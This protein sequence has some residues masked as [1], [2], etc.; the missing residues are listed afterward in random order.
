MKGRIS[1]GIFYAFFFSLYPLVAL[2]ST[3]SAVV[4]LADVLRSIWITVVGVL[5]LLGLFWIFT[6]KWHVGAILASVILILFF[7]YGHVYNIIKGT[8]VAGFDLGRHR[9]LLI[10]WAGFVLVAAFVSIRRKNSLYRLAPAL[11]AVS[12]M[13]LM[14][15]LVTIIKTGIEAKRD[16][17]RNPASYVESGVVL[18]GNED[19]LPD[20][21]YIITDAYARSDILLERYHYDNSYFMKFLAE[22]GFVIADQSTSNYLWT[23][24]SLGSSLNMDY[25]QNIVAGW[26][27]GDKVPSF[28]LIQ[29]NEVRRIFEANG[30]KTIGFATGWDATEFFDADVVLTPEMTNYQYLEK[31][32]V[33]ND[34]EGLLLS[35]SAV[36]VLIDIDSS[37][38]I[39]VEE[40][41]QQ[42]L[43]TRF[44]IQRSIIL[45]LFENLQKVPS[46]EGPKFVFAHIISPHPPII[47]GRNG[48]AVENIGPFNLDTPVDEPGEGNAAQYT[49][50]LEYIT[51]RLMETVDV[52]LRDS[53]REVYII[54][55]SD[56]GPGGG[57]E[58][59]N[60][61]E[62][63]ADR[64]S[65]L[66][67][68]YLPADCQERIYSTISPVNSF[69]VLFSCLS[70]ITYP[71][72]SDR[73][74]YGIEEF[75]PIEDFLK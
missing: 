63:L 43:R 13:M 36:R 22:K 64:M 34:F 41:I 31:T 2:W 70:D 66:N 39:P 23:H 73:T 27:Q 71:L 54:L 4:E 52:I 38:N 29:E 1:H 46:I 24:L 8:L 47:F 26:K 67:A 21:Y 51:K 62:S 19:Q 17:G 59:F 35:T 25:I 48:E 15:P 28:S 7:S 56:H 18:G 9:Y 16:V 72:L 33:V 58:Y 45:G 37:R 20:V 65:I 55:Q 42:R 3:N 57:F 61:T 40:F 11:N 32:G 49:D 5:L 44:T 6:R 14:F 74:Y 10:L 60:N 30:Y 12:A 69:R 68:Y 53:N 50:Q 75:Y